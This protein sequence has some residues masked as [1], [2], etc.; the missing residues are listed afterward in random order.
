MN[1][2]LNALDDL[3]DAI[4][5]SS[6]Y[7]RRYIVEALHGQENNLPYSDPGHPFRL[8]ATSNRIENRNRLRSRIEERVREDEDDTLSDV[9]LN[10]FTSGHDSYDELITVMRRYKEYADA[11]NSSDSD[12]D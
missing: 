3:D 11:I 6:R 1:S 5:A 4:P 12:S 9:I 8:Y 7:I 10:M 2:L